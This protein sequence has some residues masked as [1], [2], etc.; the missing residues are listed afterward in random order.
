M[1]RTDLKESRYKYFFRGILEIHIKGSQL[2]KVGI[3]LKPDR[4]NGLNALKIFV[5]G[6]DQYIEFIFNYRRWNTQQQ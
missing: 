2:Q 5:L 3:K 1:R 4:A 6:V